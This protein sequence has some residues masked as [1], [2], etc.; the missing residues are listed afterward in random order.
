M[1]SYD[2]LVLSGGSIKGIILLGS[3]QYFYDNDCLNEVKTYIGTSAGAIICYLLC[4][5][6]TPTEILVYLCVHDLLRSM[7][8]FNVLII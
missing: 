8:Y 4:I 2:T 1:N 5:G 3:L 7:T 6:Y